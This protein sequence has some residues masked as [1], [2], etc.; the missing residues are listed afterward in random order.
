MAEFNCQK[1]QKKKKKTVIGRAIP[2]SRMIVPGKA[3]RQ[4]A[5]S[6]GSAEGPKKNS[7]KLL[8][9]SSLCC[10]TIC[11]G[12]VFLLGTPKPHVGF[13]AQAPAVEH[14]SMMHTTSFLVH[15]SRL[16]RS[17]PPCM[18]CTKQC[19][20]SDVSAGHRPSEG[21]VFVMN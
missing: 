15:R 4:L 8:P 17:L 12:V 2:R 5:L 20:Y 11:K 16:P 6:H 9:S 10:G 14:P 7:P 18:Q 3:G 13:F 19:S 21:D 1:K